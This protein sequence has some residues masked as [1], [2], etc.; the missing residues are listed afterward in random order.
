IR[1][2][3]SRCL[4]W[5]QRGGGRQ[6]C[7]RDRHRTCAGLHVP[8]KDQTPSFHSSSSA[9]LGSFVASASGVAEEARTR[10]FASPAFAGFASKLGSFH[11]APRRGGRQES[12][13]GPVPL[14]LP[15]ELPH[16]R[17]ET[18]IV[19]DVGEIRIAREIGIAGPPLFGCPAQPL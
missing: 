15:L 4:G 1:R 3:G 17:D 16:E 12:Q 10:G 9:V 8:P 14:P 2:P 18:R 13:R 19:S 5:Q 11:N 6:R 7:A